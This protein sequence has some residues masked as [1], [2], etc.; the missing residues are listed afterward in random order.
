MRKTPRPGPSHPKPWSG[1]EYPRRH[2]YANGLS[3]LIS[4][5]SMKPTLPLLMALAAI[6]SAPCFGNL[7][8]D[9]S[10][11]TLFGNNPPESGT[12]RG[13][14][15]YADVGPDQTRIEAVYDI[16]DF[17]RAAD[18]VLLPVFA[19][20]DD[21]PDAVLLSAA[22]SASLDG[23]ELKRISLAANP[24]GG[25]ALPADLRI[26]WIRIET[27]AVFGDSIIRVSYRQRHI[28]GR[29]YYLA[30][31]IPDRLGGPPGRDWRFSLLARASSGK[32]AFSAG[33]S[34]W[35]RLGDV[36]VVYLRRD[37]IVSLEPR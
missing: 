15:V 12:L 27:R 36:L 18:G 13:E 6:A 10:K 9:N 25:P 31:S 22:V 37:Q 5:F 2:T 19:A 28:G 35:E 17:P 8:P 16:S 34:E 20:A 7:S 24:G 3:R 14:T 32:V 4:P 30:Q 33:S 29:F 11:V 21:D 23:T 26:V 1:D